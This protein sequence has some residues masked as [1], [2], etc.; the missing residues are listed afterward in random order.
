MY[1]SVVVGYAP[2]AASMAQQ[3][4]AKSNEMESQGWRLVSFSVT[5]SAKGILVFHREGSPDRAE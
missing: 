2:R 1:K 4:E 3:V 5:N